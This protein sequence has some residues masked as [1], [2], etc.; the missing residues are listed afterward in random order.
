MPKFSKG[1]LAVFMDPKLSWLNGNGVT[2]H[3]PTIVMVMNVRPDHCGGSH[4]CT[5][6]GVHAPRFFIKKYQRCDEYLVYGILDQ[7]FTWASE[8]HLRL[9]PHEGDT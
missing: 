4:I 6:R 9:F 7:T 5:T 8:V 3:N 1:D 2:L